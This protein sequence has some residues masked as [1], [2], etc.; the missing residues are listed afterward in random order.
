MTA[1]PRRCAPPSRGFTE[2]RCITTLSTN[3]DRIGKHHARDPQAD[4]SIATTTLHW[5]ETLCTDLQGGGVAESSA[6][7]SS[8][9]ERDID[10]HR[11]RRVDDASGGWF[12]GGGPGIED[13]GLV[14]GGS[15]CGKQPT[16]DGRS[17]IPPPEQ[18]QLLSSDRCLHLHC[19]DVPMICRFVA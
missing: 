17:A 15:Q 2:S 12:E 10:V 16:G 5:L 19:C 3:N 6:S 18:S 8:D 1:V 13:A 4:E 7:G 14:V 11:H 9:G